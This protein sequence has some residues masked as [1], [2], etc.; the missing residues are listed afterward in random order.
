MLIF[1]VIVYF[2]ITIL[3]GFYANRKI[4]GG[5]DF[6]NAGRNLHPVINA[7]ALFALWFGSETLFGASAEFAKGGLRKVIEDPFG[8]MLC[9]LLV[10]FVYSKK[11]YRL[12]ILTIGDLFEIRFGKRVEIFA[13]FLMV[14]SFIGYIAA[15]L[16]AMSI[17]FKILL[18]T[19]TPVGV[20]LAAAIVVLYTVSGGM[21]AVSLTDFIQSIMIIIGLGA[22]TWVVVD[23]AGGLSPIV[24]SIPDDYWKFLPEPTWKERINWIAAWTMLGLGSLVSQDIFQRVNSARSEKAAYYSSITGAMIYGCVAFIPMLI[25]MGIKLIYPEYADGDLQYTLP[26]MVLDKLPMWLKILFF[27]SVM[28]AIMSTCS[29]AILAPASLISE[30]IIRPLFFNDEDDKKLLLITRLS[31]IGITLISILIS[32]GSDSIYSLVGEASAF[33]LVSIFIPYTAALFWDY[34]NKGGAVFSMIIGTVVWGYSKFIAKTEINPIVYGTAGAAL[35]M[36]IGHVLYD[37]FFSKE[38]RT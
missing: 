19:S 24:K 26:Q 16:V 7:F 2:L 31:I 12:N 37:Q 14:L 22:I 28:S 29:G 15:Q 4:S 34:D 32:F 25:I 18:G 9:L 13:S 21:L 38:S 30:N 33:G 5:S 3:V 8:G 11:M 36:I 1:F 10:G 6:I 17:M 20:F 23:Q 27:G 35:G